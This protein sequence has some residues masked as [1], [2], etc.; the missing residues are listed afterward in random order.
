MAWRRLD[1][2]QFKVTSCDII[3]DTSRNIPG[4]ASLEYLIVLVQPFTVRVLGVMA[5]A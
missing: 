4:G 5:M 1:N 2:L 3:R